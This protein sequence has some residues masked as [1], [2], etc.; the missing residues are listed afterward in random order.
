MSSVVTDNQ[1][2]DKLIVA[3]ASFFGIATVASLVA[4]GSKLWFLAAKLIQRNRRLRLLKRSA[5]SESEMAAQL[6]VHDL[7]D[8]M[9][10]QKMELKEALTYV[11]HAFAEDLP[12]V[13]PCTNTLSAQ[14]CASLELIVRSRFFWGREFA[15]PCTSGRYSSLCPQGRRPFFSWFL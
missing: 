13:C 5:D 10:A 9:D 7:V 3:F 4:F 1:A 2:G 6:E 11:L 8:E 15:M 12:M 14:C